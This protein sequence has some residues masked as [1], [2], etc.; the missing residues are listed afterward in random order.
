MYLIFAAA[1]RWLYQNL[2]RVYTKAQSGKE[3]HIEKQAKQRRLCSRRLRVNTF[4]RHINFITVLFNKWGTCAGMQHTE[5]NDQ[6]WRGI[7]KMEC[8][9][10]GM[11]DRG[12][13]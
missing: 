7:E 4:L 5:T 2:R 1:T 3:N 13:G 8:N 6:G 12:I 9:I 10:S 11:Y